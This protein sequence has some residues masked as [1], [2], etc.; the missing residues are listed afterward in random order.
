MPLSA[1]GVPGGKARELEEDFPSSC[2]LLFDRSAPVW[3]DMECL[4]VL[5]WIVVELLI[6]VDK[7]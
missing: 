1:S 7:K 4:A 6:R 2:K 3:L 5:G